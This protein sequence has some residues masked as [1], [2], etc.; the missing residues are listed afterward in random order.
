MRFYTKSNRFYCGVDL[1]ARTMHLCILD[2]DGNVVFDR[3]LACHPKAFL[4]AIAAFRDGIV[5]GCEC[6]FGWYWLADV[7]R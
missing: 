1:H 2:H 4:G 5:V 6:M 3:N 7:C